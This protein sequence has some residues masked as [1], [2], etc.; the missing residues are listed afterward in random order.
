MSNISMVCDVCK[1]L[2]HQIPNKSQMSP[3]HYP[4]HC[5]DL[6]VS[7]YLQRGYGQLSHDDT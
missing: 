7:T 4:S 6:Q 3:D 2:K 1:G 5:S